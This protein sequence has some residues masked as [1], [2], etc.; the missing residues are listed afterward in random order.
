MTCVQTTIT[1][2]KNFD[3]Y[4]VDKKEMNDHDSNII[5]QSRLETART[6]TIEKPYVFKVKE[7]DLSIVYGFLNYENSKKYHDSCF[8]KIKSRCSQ[9]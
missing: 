4:Y 9:K 1:Y 2:D 8:D 7:D 6:A 5:N 3:K